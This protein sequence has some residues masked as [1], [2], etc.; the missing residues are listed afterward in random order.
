M[1]W[2]SSCSRKSTSPVKYPRPSESI[3]HQPHTELAG[4]RQQP[5]FDIAAEDRVLHLD[6][7]NRVDLVGA[8][9]FIGSHLGQARYGGSCQL[10]PIPCMRRQCLRSARANPP[11]GSSRGRCALYPTA[12]RLSSTQFLMNS[13]S[14]LARGSPGFFGLMIPALVAS[15]TS[16]HRVFSTCESSFFVVALPVDIGS[17]KEGDPAIQHVVQRA[18]GLFWSSADRYGPLSD[19]PAETL[20]VDGSTLGRGRCQLRSADWSCRILLPVVISVRSRA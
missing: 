12:S 13:G 4:G 8:A 16:S 2:A 7:G 5:A 15:V 1:S 17:I 3:G 10:Q 18:Q 9:Q 19:M 6:R 14:P 20:G 11:G